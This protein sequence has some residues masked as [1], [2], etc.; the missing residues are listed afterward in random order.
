MKL[1]ES[2]E[3]FLS[4]YLDINTL[5]VDLQTL[6][7]QSEEIIPNPEQIF[8]VFRYMEPEQ[9]KVVLFGEDPYPRRSSAN[10]VAF[11]DAEI[12]TWNN[13]TN[14]NSLK[15]I[16]KAMLVS[17][18]L[19]VYQTPIS[20]C[21]ELANENN[22][23]T[24]PELFEQWLDQGILLLNTA[25]TF[26]GN[27]EKKKHFAFWMPFHRALISALNN[28]MEVPYYILWGK[29]AQKW[30]SI[31]SDSASRPAK[32]IRQGHPTFIHQ[33]LRKEEPQYSPFTEIIEKTGLSWF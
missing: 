9:V 28:R 10:G 18:G 15:N 13:K 16:L 30:E 33:F 14:G 5:Y 26:T 6:V 1:P 17:K 7:S 4:P 20:E 27:I 23:V 24:P 19:A 29:K 11:W 21:R 25:L 31:I 22:Y 3:L 2:W 32:I 8:N 12:K